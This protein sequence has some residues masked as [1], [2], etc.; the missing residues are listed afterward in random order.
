MSSRKVR[1]STDMYKKVNQHEHLLM[2][3]DS[4][5]GSIEPISIERALVVLPFTK[6]MIRFTR[7]NVQCVPALLKIVDEIL[8]N[9]MDH[10]T[11][12]RTL[13]RTQH[14]MTRLDVVVHANT[15]RVRVTNNGRGI[16]VKQLSKYDGVYAPEL[17]FG[18][19]LTSSN[20]DDATQRVTG[21]RNG[22][23][24]KCTNIYSTE[25]S[26]ET[27]DGKRVYAQTW[28]DNMY[29]VDT[30]IIRAATKKD[31]LH[32]TVEFV[33]DFARLGGGASSFDDDTMALLRRRV[34][35]AAMWCRGRVVVTFN[36]TTIDMSGLNQLARCIVGDDRPLLTHRT[37]DGR[38]EFV[39]TYGD[40]NTFEHVS[41]VNGI[42]TKRGG[43]HVE[44]VAKP[45]AKALA[46][47]ITKREK[48][49]VTSRSVR[50]QLLLFVRAVIVNPAFDGQ[51]KELLT[52]PVTRFGSRCDLPKTIASTM[53]HNVPEFTA[54]VVAN[55]RYRGSRALKRTDGSKTSS[56]RGIPKLC[57]AA[58]AGTRDARKT[59]LII[60]EGDSAKTMALSGLSA[61]QNGREWYGVFPL[62]G[63]LQNV[64]GLD[65][66]R[67]A[68]NI[69]IT[70]LK[71]VLGLKTGMT[72]NPGARTW[73]LRYGKMI[74]MTDQDVD[75]SHIKGLVA[76]L[77]Q[78]H[79]PSLLKLNFMCA[80][81]TP[82]VKV[83]SKRAPRDSLFFY[84]MTDYDS[85]CRA[86]PRCASTHRTKYY[87]GLGTSSAIEAKEYFGRHK[88]EV[89]YEFSDQCD[90]AL[91]L[92]FDKTRSNDRKAW[93]SH[94]NA[95][96]VLDAKRTRVSFT[97]FVHRELIHFSHY[98]VRR[99]I[100]SS[101]DG[102]KPSQRKILFACFKR[103]LTHEIKVA[104][105]AGY[106]SEHAAYHHG[107]MSLHGTIIKMA[108]DF[109]GSN[110]L[111]LLV[112]CGQ[113]G[114][115]LQGGT[116]AASPRYIFTRLHALASMIFPSADVPLLGAL[117]DDGLRIEPARYVPV[118]PM[119]LVNGAKGIGT[120][121]ST[122]VPPHNPLDIVDRVLSWIA[123]NAILPL[124]PW[125]RGFKGVVECTHD[126][127]FITRGCCQLE[128][129]VS[130]RVTELPIGTWTEQY[131][132]YIEK[133]IAQQT[134]GIAD[135][136]DRSTHT[137]VD[138]LLIFK[139]ANQMNAL[140]PRKCPHIFQRALGLVSRK[141]CNYRNMHLFD[142][143]GNIQHFATTTDIIR[144]FCVVRK[145]L[146]ERR[147]AFELARLVKKRDLAN[148]KRR[149][150]EDVI[151]GRIVLRNK[152]M[153]DL[154][155]ELEERSYDPRKGGAPFSGRG[156]FKHLHGMPLSSITRE[157]A[158]QL[159]N[160]CAAAE[161]A[162]T[163]LEATTPLSIW[164]QELM[165]I[166][167]M[168]TKEFIHGGDCRTV[169]HVV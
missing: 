104:Q 49:K 154:E 167:Q 40:S 42:A 31:R 151:A 110:N 129:D 30:P 133:K 160:D 15:G 5:V 8:V 20:Y 9:A 87:K 60:T 68:K 168:Y 165:T 98:D 116:D 137:R 94:Y 29:T 25:F 135:Y 107:E 4:Y 66:E 64:R 145:N 43:R 155:Q 83:W 139:S 3:P 113:F 78:T 153:N 19:L 121:W 27:C 76:N 120:G 118:I 2:R 132:I 13:P 163:T 108:Q 1:P 99:S 33:P 11:T 32:T 62:K 102:L 109:V 127:S 149:F 158:H 23:G 140:Q 41:F 46:T 53:L 26:I 59:T 156:R 106:V 72:I 58:R 101:I 47:L 45:F 93:L 126:T 147:Y 124:Q 143:S 97:E 148:E 84:N 61:V 54:R 152:P 114:S 136:E 65:S 36:G 157:R 14:R 169:K 88:R 166:R 85:W 100:P 125:F 119:V 81:V 90:D 134:L 28:R 51:M 74:M 92:A 73:P 111:P 123:G 117:D 164:K 38:W 63:K 162:R 91:C 77:F 70:Q 112:P 24:A 48:L 50:S 144:D 75:G 82:I 103:Q 6:S 56:I 57:D 22:Y 150:V 35:D 18:H 86:H 128:S 131:K 34:V 141:R 161:R 52:T 7:R 80:L 37:S 96:N 146:Y 95:S 130:V 39:A 71:R 44:H 16:P 79:W 10:W 138:I 122:D 12:T 89:T 159:R 67:V 21:G 142:A 55:A 69:E 115:R 17:V 105:L